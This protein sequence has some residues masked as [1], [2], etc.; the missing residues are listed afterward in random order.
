[1]D[2]IR[3]APETARFAF[4]GGKPPNNLVSQSDKDD[5]QIDTL[6]FN[7]SYL[8]VNTSKNVEGSCRVANRTGDTY[9]YLYLLPGNTLG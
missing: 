1:M 4:H 8:S 7:R 6:F 3:T 9:F 5:D 2:C